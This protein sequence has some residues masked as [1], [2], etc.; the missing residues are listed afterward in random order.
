M[1]AW[2]T[3][4]PKPRL[5]TLTGSRVEVISWRACSNSGSEGRLDMV[6]DG[7]LKSVKVEGKEKNQLTGQEKDEEKR[8]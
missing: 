5:E 3:D 7:S 2:V 6:K 1:G 4:R 8:Y